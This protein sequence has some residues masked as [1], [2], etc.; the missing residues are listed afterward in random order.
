[1]R[2]HP[3]VPGVT[4]NKVGRSP[5]LGLTASALLI[6]AVVWWI[7]TNALAYFTGLPTIL[8]F[9]AVAGLT[10][11][12]TRNGIRHSLVPSTYSRWVALLLA[13]QALWWAAFVEESGWQ[14]AVIVLFGIATIRALVLQRRW[15]NLLKAYCREENAKEDER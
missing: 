2:N 13:S 14:S 15:I 11:Q 4:A 6:T 9:F 3:E 1:M 5:L 7:M 8:A 12:I 10:S